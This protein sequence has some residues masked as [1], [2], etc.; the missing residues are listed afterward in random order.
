MP[1]CLAFFLQILYTETDMKHVLYGNGIDDDTQ[2]IQDLLDGEESVVKL[3]RPEK[4]YLIS[5]PL[6]IGGGKTLVL[7]K[8][9][10]IRLA[11]NSDCL[12]LKNKPDARENVAL[13]GGIWDMNNQHQKPN[14][15]VKKVEGDSLD[16]YAGNAVCEAEIFG[17]KTARATRFDDSVYFG[18][19]MAFSDIKNLT[20]K[21]VTFKDPVTYGCWFGK[22]DGFLV[23]NITFDYNDG[24]PYPVNMDGV[25]FHGLC[26]NGVIRNMKGAC[27]DDMIAFS[28]D[29]FIAGD[30]ENVVV[31]NIEAYDCHSAVR[32]LAVDHCVRNVAIRNIRGTFYQYCIGFTKYY[33]MGNGV[34]GR[35]ENILAENC[36]I[37]KAPMLKKYKKDASHRYPL[38][39]FQQ[40]TVSENVII[41]NIVRKETDCAVPLIGAEDGVDLSGVKAENIEQVSFVGD[42][43]L[44]GR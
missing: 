1:R 16:I 27:Y 18:F 28:A 29:E 21:D 22:I 35:F 11:D 23:E 5:A 36:E 26:R 39:Y 33:A 4:N 10:V 40:E 9:A 34:C 20:V 43:P 32:L 12:M 14:P 24:N 3:P 19:L 17:E 41:R 38:F 25:H 31:E 42:V 8:D 13:I 2:A 37:A 6:K 7:E 15:V 44:I 30:I